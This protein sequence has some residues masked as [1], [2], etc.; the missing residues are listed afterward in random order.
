[1]AWYLGGG[2]KPNELEELTLRDRRLV[3]EALDEFI[4]E[5]NE[6]TEAAKK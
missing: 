1:M 4:A 3:L 5:E 6:R 2:L